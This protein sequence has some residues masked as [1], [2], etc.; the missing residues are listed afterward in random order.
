MKTERS[1]SADREIVAGEGLS[2]DES[3]NL[4]VDRWSQRVDQIVD[5]RRPVRSVLAEKSSRLAEAVILD[6]QNLH[7]RL[8]GTMP[9]FDGG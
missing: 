5:E 9:R 1:I 8:I 7:A 6:R 2:P 4:F 3:E